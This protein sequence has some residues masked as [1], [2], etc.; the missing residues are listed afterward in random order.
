MAETKPRAK[1][2]DIAIVGGPT[3][4]GQG[5]RILRIR[6]GNLTAGEIRPVKEGEPITE[7]EV[8]RLRPL[9]EERRICEVEVLHAPPSLP[10]NEDTPRRAR[11]SNA[12]YRKNWDAIFDQKR[13]RRGKEDYEMN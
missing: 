11:V 7:R 12:S 1:P 6:D 3:E 2:K 5:A 13:K 9:D 4:D 10:K 8:V